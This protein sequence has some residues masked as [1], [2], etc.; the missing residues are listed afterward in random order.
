MKSKNWT[1][2]EKLQIVLEGLKEKTTVAELCNKYGV[3]QSQY[4]KWR[5]QL[6]EDGGK[7]FELNSITRQEQRLQT[8]NINLKRIIGD[9]T[10]ELKKNEYDL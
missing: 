3:H 6:L 10:V 7:A 9:L 5:T 4:Y 8:E 2:K 1:S